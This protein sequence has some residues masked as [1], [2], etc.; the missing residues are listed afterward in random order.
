MNDKQWIVLFGDPVQGFTYHGT[1][2]TGDEACEYGDLHRGNAGDEY[3]VAPLQFDVGND[4]G[5]GKWGCKDCYPDDE[6]TE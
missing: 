5:C 6:V 3:W 1:F 4:E 2:D